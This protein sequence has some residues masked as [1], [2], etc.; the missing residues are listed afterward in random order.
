MYLS[1]FCQLGVILRVY[2]VELFG[3]A[4]DTSRNGFLYW[5]PCV[6]S[7]GLSRYGGAFFSNLPP[8]V[9]GSF[10]M[11]LFASSATL[12]AAYP[13]FDSGVKAPSLPAMAFLPPTSPLQQ[14]TALHL[15]LRT[16]FCGS[17]TTFASWILQMVQMMVGGKVSSLG[18]EW[19][20]ALWGLFT[21]VAVSM[22]ALVMGQ[23]LALVLQAWYNTGGPKEGEHTKSPA[24]AAAAAATA[25]AAVMVVVEGE[26]GEEE[27]A[28]PPLPAPGSDGQVRLAPDTS[29]SWQYHVADAAT[30]I[31]LLFLTSISI[32]YAIIQGAWSSADAGSSS[33]PYVSRYM[34]FSI[35]FG[36]LGCITRWLLAKHLNGRQ[37]FPWG[38]WSANLLACAIDFGLQAIIVRVSIDPLQMVILKAIMTGINGSLSTVS[39][40][41]VEIQTLSLAFPSNARGYHYAMASMVPAVLLGLA[42]YGTSVWTL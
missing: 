30:L 20:A 33:N 17:L 18:T 6:T 40:W 11:G 13:N 23:H 21:N 38:T 4:C 22:I 37:W 39:T 27:R 14:H 32:A 16:G 31:M 42:I 28:P 1:A 8:N 25:T 7:P 10:A 34:W 19:V 24:A 35:I 3:D 12:A 15:G 36:P 9:A 5:S 41:V 26:K 2:M 29:T